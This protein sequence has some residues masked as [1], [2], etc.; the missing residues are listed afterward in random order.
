MTVTRYVECSKADFERV[1]RTSSGSW[2]KLYDR[3]ALLV[4]AWTEHYD[5]NIRYTPGKIHGLLPIPSLIN[6]IINHTFLPKSGTSRASLSYS[7]S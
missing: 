4:P 3:P 2:E 6:R 1:L 5:G 7:F